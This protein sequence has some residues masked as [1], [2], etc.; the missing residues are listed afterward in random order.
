MKIQ[1]KEHLGITRTTMSILV[2]AFVF[3]CCVGPCFV[4]WKTLTNR[5][6]RPR[7]RGLASTKQLA[8]DLKAAANEA[9]DAVKSQVKVVVDVVASAQM[10][11]FE[12]AAGVSD[13]LRVV[14]RRARVHR[15]GA[16]AADEPARTSTHSNPMHPDGE[17]PSPDFQ[18]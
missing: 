14:N 10:T 15:I 11:A 18:P 12:S 3:P 7:D 17:P 8:D 16:S 1:E 13:K 5:M 6:K 4:F 2:V 9:R